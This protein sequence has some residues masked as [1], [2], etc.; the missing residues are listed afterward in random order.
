MRICLKFKCRAHWT[1]AHSM[2]FNLNLTNLVHGSFYPARFRAILMVHI[3]TF[4]V[5]H[6]TRHRIFVFSLSVRI[7]SFVRFFVS[8]P[9]TRGVEVTAPYRHHYLFLE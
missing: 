9:N 5:F 4:F 7:I 3:L 6:G 2:Y 1:L 8:A